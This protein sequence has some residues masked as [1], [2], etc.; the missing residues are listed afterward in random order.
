MGTRIVV[1][2]QEY[3]SEK[4]MPAAV[5]QAYEQA[6][7][8][9]AD[10]DRNGVPDLLEDAAA[11]DVVSVRRSSVTV[12]GR[13]YGSIDELP[14]F[15]RRLLG[16]AVLASGGGGVLGVPET[17]AEGQTPFPGAEAGHQVLG[18][19]APDGGPAITQLDRIDRTLEGFFRVLLG[20]VMVG[21]V[22]GAVFLMWVMDAGSRSQGGRFYLA[23]LAVLALGAT[24]RQ[25]DWL[26]RRRSALSEPEAYRRYR[27]CSFALLL[28]VAAALVG[29]GLFFP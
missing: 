24:D 19:L 12:N 15:L 21:I 11:R 16:E 20:S 28:A 7:A 25:L 4:A 29:L 17:A 2:G 1:N 9:L 18:G 26:V 14:V 10:A 27:L 22:A 3:A 6:L 8:Q 5:R 23:V 13:T